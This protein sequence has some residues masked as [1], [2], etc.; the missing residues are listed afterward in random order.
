[1]KRKAIKM[2][3]STCNRRANKRKF[4]T[5]IMKTTSPDKEFLVIKKSLDSSPIVIIEKNAPSIRLG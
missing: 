4:A 1:M 2:I 5:I 3:D